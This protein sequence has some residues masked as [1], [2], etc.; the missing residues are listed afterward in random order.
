MKITRIYASE[1]GHSH[2]E[3]IDIDL[4]EGGA[5]GRMSAAQPVKEIVFR[6]NDPGYDYD[7]HHAPARQYVVLLDGDTEIEVSDGEKRIFRGGEVLLVED[8][9]GRGH[10]TRTIN[11][12]SRRSIFLVLN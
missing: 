11:N 4:H 3:D 7:W 10:R 8:T 2:F 5:L 9:T 6:E 12:R 1:D